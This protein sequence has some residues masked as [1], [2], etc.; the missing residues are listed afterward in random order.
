MEVIRIPAKPKIQKTG[1]LRVAAY[2]RVSSRHKEQ[3]ESLESQLIYYERKIKDEKNW[4]Y[5]GVYYDI[6]SGL[7]KEHRK[8]LAKLLKQVEKGKLDLIITKSVSRL[9]RNTVDVLEAV[10]LMKEKG[11]DMYF[12]N[13]NIRLSE[14]Q[15]ELLL[16][17][18]CAVAQEE[19][20]NIS[21]N[22]KWGYTRKFERGEI[23]TK[24][25]N[26]MGYTEKDGKLVIVL[27]E[28]E[29]VRTIF[30]M[31]AAGNS[32]RK[33]CVYLE[34]NGIKTKT[35][36]TKWA[37]N[38][39][40]KMLHNEKYKGCTL[41]QKTYSDDL[42]SGKRKKNNGEVTQ[43]YYEDTHPAIVSKEL[44]ERVQ[45]RLDQNR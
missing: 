35:G 17:I 13:E 28:A 31:Y 4:L 7:R 23:Q 32:I 45:N 24:Y 40:G 37:P 14:Q 22:I 1:K 27:E 39:I 36:K 19:S 34:E 26:F 44:F 8:G 16:S 33:I 42:L 11:V 43:Y 15:M 3:V 20:R 18:R 38:V 9:G 21:E 25:K 6:G 29:I 30:E 12:E 10:R 41:M 5:R 2:C